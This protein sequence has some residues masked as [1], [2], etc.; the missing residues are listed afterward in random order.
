MSDCIHAC[1]CVKKFHKS[2]DSCRLTSGIS[3]VVT[4]PLA[5]VAVKKRKFVSGV[6][7]V[8][9]ILGNNVFPDLT[10]FLGERAS[11]T[12]CYLTK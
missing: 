10:L 1:V 7:S 11:L 5:T 3:C 9:N 12:V 6:K 4:I 8:K 2:F